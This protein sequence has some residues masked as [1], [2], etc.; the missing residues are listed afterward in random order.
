M[1][2]E[3]QLTEKY[4][5][6]EAD[7]YEVPWDVAC[8]FSNAIDLFGYLGNGDRIGRYA[9]F[10]GPN[11]EDDEHDTGELDGMLYNVGL[12][13]GDAYGRVVIEFDGGWLGWLTPEEFKLVDVIEPEINYIH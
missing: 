5:A 2:D 13:V 10:I 1:S 3:N 4:G 12:I 6:G 7:V 8:T 11:L 9:Q